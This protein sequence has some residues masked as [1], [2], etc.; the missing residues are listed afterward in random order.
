LLLAA[1]L[2]LTTTSSAQQK[3]KQS[4]DTVTRE[5]ATLQ[6]YTNLAQVKEISCKLADLS[7]DSKTMTFTIEWSHVE[8]NPNAKGNVNQK[9]AQLQ[10]QL[11]R[12]YNTA[13]SSKNPIHQQQALMRFQQR[14]QQ[15]QT[16]GNAA[17]QNMFMVVKSSKDFNVTIKDNIKVARVQ[18]EN[19]YNDEGELI[20]YTAEEL[21]K[22]KSTD[23]TGAYKAVPEDLK[24]GQTV[25]LY[26]SPP[27]KK[28]EKKSDSSS[29]DSSD[30]KDKATDNG[31]PS[32]RPQVRMVLIQEEPAPAPEPD[33][34]AKKKKKKG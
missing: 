24:I 3:N 15:L 7:L 8:P 10:Q 4:K 17:L 2:V 23:I 30:T 26:L 33:D 29:A 34:T 6:D 22:M 27:P 14:L 16:S 18:L 20:K 28:Q 21:K 5:E 12:D 1:L 32:D 9:T 13:M 11:M 19:K 31:I 25:T